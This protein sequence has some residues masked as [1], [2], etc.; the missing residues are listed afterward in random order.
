MYHPES[1]PCDSL[2]YVCKELDSVSMPMKEVV[3]PSLMPSHALTEGSC[4][5]SEWPYV[6]YLQ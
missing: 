4:Q 2:G 1:P 5:H 6:S 3:F